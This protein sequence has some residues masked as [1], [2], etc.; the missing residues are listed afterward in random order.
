MEEPDI[1]SIAISPGRVDTEMQR[2]LRDAGTAMKPSDRQ[3]FVDAFEQGELI[4]PEVP[5]SAVARLVVDPPR[6]L[7]GKFLKYVSRSLLSW[8]TL[9]GSRLMAPELASYVSQ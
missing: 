8:S 1:A 2:E 3:S 9:S 6:E 5:G 7:S 4:K